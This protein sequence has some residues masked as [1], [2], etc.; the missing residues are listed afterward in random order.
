M[1]AADNSYI[2]VKSLWVVNSFIEKCKLWGN[3]LLGVTVMQYTFNL[4]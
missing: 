2:C 4:S 3:T 1:V